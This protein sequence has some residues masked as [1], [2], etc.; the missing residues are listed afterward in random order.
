MHRRPQV[1]LTSGGMALEAAVAVSRQIDPEVAALAVAGLVYRAR[2]AEPMAI[3]MTGDEAQE[4]QDLLD[5]D[6]RTQ[7]GEIDGWHDRRIRQSMP[8]R[9]EDRVITS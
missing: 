5:R 2:A 6:L 7:L 8:D 1:E 3:A 4:R 9:E